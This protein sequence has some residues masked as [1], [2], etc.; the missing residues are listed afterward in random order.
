MKQHKLIQSYVREKWFVST[1]FRKSSI[2][3]ITWYYETILWEWDK[4]TKQRGELLQTFDSGIF[5]GTA[6]REHAKICSELP[7]GL[8]GRE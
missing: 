8:E 5:P 2:D 4:E 3:E 1:A 6:L 7:M